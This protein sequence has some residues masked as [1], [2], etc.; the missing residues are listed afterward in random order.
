MKTNF[1]IFNLII[2]C[3]IIFNLAI[4]NLQSVNAQ[5]YWNQAGNF[6]ATVGSHVAV[7][8]SASLNLTGSFTL[9][10]LI[11]PTSTSFITRGIFSKGTGLGIKYFMRL[12]SCRISILTN[13][14]ERL[15]SRASNPILLNT[16]THL[17]ATYDSTVGTY[18]LYINGILDTT[19]TFPGTSPSVS[20]DSLLIGSSGSSTEFGGQIDDVR[21]WNV[22]LANVQIALLMKSSLGISGIGTIT[23]K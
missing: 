19:T 3:L 16:W 21:I 2:F 9:E 23:D 7:A 14:A 8:P 13:A 18:K 1:K 12:T 11:N 5:M 15:T 10:A 6:P 4:L 22:S 20:T 17:A